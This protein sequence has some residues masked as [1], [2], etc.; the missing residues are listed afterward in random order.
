MVDYPPT[1]ED[2]EP[3][4]GEMSK[5]CDSPMSGVQCI[6]CG[7]CGLCGGINLPNG[8]CMPE[9]DYSNKK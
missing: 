3:Y 4:Q 8:E 6:A 1:K 7:A 2:E 5:C 9:E